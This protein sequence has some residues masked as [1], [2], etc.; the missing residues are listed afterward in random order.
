M[1]IDTLPVRSATIRQ[2]IATGDFEGA[3]R[4]LGRRV[5]ATGELDGAT[6]RFPIPVALPPEGDYRAAVEPA[7]TVTGRVA[8][9]RPGVVRV[10]ADRLLLTPGSVPSGASR[11]RVAFSQRLPE[12][13]KPAILRRSQK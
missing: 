3:R 8:P 2:A 11:A 1:A 12:K 6:V 4:L 7:W 5:A 10:E 13:A 9:A